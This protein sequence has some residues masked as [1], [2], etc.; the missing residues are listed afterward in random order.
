MMF[1]SV[2]MTYFYFQVMGLD[3]FQWYSEMLLH[4]IN[5]KKIQFQDHIQ[6]KQKK[7]ILFT[8]NLWKKTVSSNSAN[9]RSAVG[10]QTKDNLFTFFL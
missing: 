2:K 9:Y 5:I 8:V 4:T 10:L 3:L 7:K 6:T 1:L